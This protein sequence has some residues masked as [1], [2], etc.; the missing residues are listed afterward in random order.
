MR[1]ECDL[2]AQVVHPFSVKLNI[3]PFFFLVGVCFVDS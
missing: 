3:F 2:C 1:T